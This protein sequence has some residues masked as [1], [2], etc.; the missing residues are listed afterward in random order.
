[1]SRVISGKDAPEVRPWSI[2]DVDSV[3]PHSDEVFQSTGDDFDPTSVRE[4]QQKKEFDGGYNEGFAK[5]YAEGKQAAEEE[6]ER[7][8]SGLLMTLNFLSR[9]V[10]NLEQQV[11]H[12]LLELS[13]AVAKQ[14]LKREISLQPKHIIGLIRASVA[15]LPV[16]ESEVSVHLN[17]DDAKII[18]NALN[19]SENSQRWKIVEDPGLNQGACIVNSDSSFVD[20]SVDAMVKQVALDLFGGQRSNE[21]ERGGESDILDG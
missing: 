9:P 8:R 20:G 7:D 14:I 21:R 10:E 4:Q 12:E 18:R 3:N 19:T 17:P 2:P 15:R 16:A 1:M 6:L 11:E 5:G 13:L